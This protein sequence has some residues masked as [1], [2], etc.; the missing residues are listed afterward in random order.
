[1]DKRIRATAWCFTINN[2]TDQDIQQAQAL[3][4]FVIFGYEVGAEGTP[5]LQGYY[6]APRRVDR[7]A[8][9]K[10]LPRAHLAP[11]APKATCWDNILYVTKDGKYWTNDEEFHHIV[12]DGSADKDWDKMMQVT[13]YQYLADGFGRQDSRYHVEARQSFWTKNYK[14]K[15]FNAF[16]HRNWLNTDQGTE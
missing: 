5:H 14:E 10:K 11:R 4:G 8:L 6:E 15:Y 3:D 1:M 16:K 7:S 12:N 2:Y 9:S 13:Y